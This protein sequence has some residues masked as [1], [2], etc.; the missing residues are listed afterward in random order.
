MF[1][2]EFLQQARCEVR[3]KT[4]TYRSVQRF[5]LVLLLHEHPQIGHDEAGHRVGFSGDQV[6]RWRKRWVRGDFSV[7]DVSGRGRSA[8]FSPA[9]PRSG[10]SSGL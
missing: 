6:R 4:A 10:Q 9:G 2:D 5:Q 7:D 3:R 1:P 8:A